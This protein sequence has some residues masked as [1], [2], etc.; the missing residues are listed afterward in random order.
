M[1]EQQLDI[2]FGL[3]ALANHRMLRPYLRQYLATQA[4]SAVELSED[5]Q[6]EALKSFAREHQ[7]GSD[8]ELENYRIAN[9][10][11]PAALKTWIEI[12][13]RI[14]IHCARVY[15]PK[16]ESRFLERKDELDKVVYSLLRLGNE[17]LA[18]ELYLQL[19]AGES[20]FPELAA[21]YAE[22]PER[23]TNGIVGPVALAQ[24]HPDFVKRLK[25][26]EPGVLN[27]PFQVEKW[28]ILMRV[29][30]Y[31]YAEF[32]EQI[33]GQMSRELFEQDIENNLE[34]LIDQIRKQL[35]AQ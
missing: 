14:E 12:N 34:L 25:T 28:W 20:S 19:T 26:A 10:L 29:E 11:S 31:S 13:K 27:E 2:P 6:L 30:S 18:H 24:A 1:P 3:D 21:K 16:A 23:M 33:A 5:E 17:Y 8:Q 7:I 22:G 32:D 35:S 15:R 9:L 4:V